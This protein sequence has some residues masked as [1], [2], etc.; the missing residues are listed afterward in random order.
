MIEYIKVL[1]D[2]DFGLE[3]KPFDHPT[4][5]YGARGIILNEAGEVGLLHKAKKHGYKLIGGGIE[6]GEDPKVA[7]EREAMEESGCEI[8]IDRLLGEF[9]EEKSQDNFQQISYIFVAHVTNDT[10]HLHLTDQEIK[11]GAE[12]VWLPLAE[13]A[14]KIKASEDTVIGSEKID[15]YHSRFIVRR[16]YEIL[17]YYI[18]LTDKE[19]SNAKPHRNI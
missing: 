15:T 4:V 8:K 1:T 2:A 3:T 18:A 7:F 11:E 17:K 13:A 14:A 5:R 10:E 6:E 9:K 16:D 19:K 12:L